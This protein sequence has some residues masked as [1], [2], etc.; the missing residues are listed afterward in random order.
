LLYLFG[1]A[2]PDTIAPKLELTSPADGS[3]HVLPV[4]L[5]LYGEVT[6]DL[7]PQFYAIE[8]RQGDAVVFTGEGIRVDLALRNPPPAQH[9]LVV[10]VQDEAGNAGTD[11]V[12]FT[13]LPE[14]S[15]APDATAAETDAGETDAGE[16][17]AEDDGR[18]CA[19]S[20]APGPLGLLLL[21]LRPRRR[22]R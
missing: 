22:R 2:V 11:R 21:L 13:T 7:E 16:A 15:E 4:D 18:G 20:G 3:F 19:I 6:D 5:S 12:R 10:P 1:P 8:V 14:G 17:T 9:D